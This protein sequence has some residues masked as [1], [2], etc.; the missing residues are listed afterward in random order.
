M[1]TVVFAP[2]LIEYAFI[3]VFLSDT[4][5]WEESIKMNHATRFNT[6]TLIKFL[7]FVPLF[8]AQKKHVLKQAVICAALGRLRWSL[9]K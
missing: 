6:F 3:A 4:N 5:L 1:D 7:V 9:L 2:D 8:N